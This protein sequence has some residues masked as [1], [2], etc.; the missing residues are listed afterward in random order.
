MPKESI[1]GDG[2]YDVRV[3]WQNGCDMQIGVEEEAGF[4]LVTALYGD[5]ETC[6]LIGLAV[7]AHCEVG[8]VRGMDAFMAL[9][10]DVLNIVEGSASSPNGSY[11]GV[12]VTLSRQGANRLI[13]VLRRAR[14]AAYGRDE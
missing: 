4:S 11:T 13:R 2:R 5:P 9:G 3:G 14:D 12:W 10:R 7:A 1:S 8:V 6:R